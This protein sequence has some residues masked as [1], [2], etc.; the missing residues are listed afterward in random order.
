MAPPSKPSLART[1]VRWT[2]L[3]AFL[4]RG[5]WLVT[6]LYLV[7]DAELSALQLVALGTAQGLT[8][9][10]CEIPTGLVADLWSRKWS[11]VIAHGLMG[12][13]MFATGLTTDFGWLVLTQMVWGLSWTF[14]SGADVAWLTDELA[15]PQVTSG[16]L[17]RAARWA[18]VGSA[19]GLVCFGLLG[20]AS[21]LSLAMVIA[22]S[23]MLLLGGYVVIAFHETRSRGT[24]AERIS[25]ARRMSKTLRLGMDYAANNLSIRLVLLVTLLVNGADEA[26][27]RL[28]AKR[29]LELGL[30]QAPDPILWLTVLGL[31][32]LAVGAL[33]LLAIEARLNERAV[34]PRY[35]FIATL[36]A[37]AG[38]GLFAFAPGPLV[39]MLGVVMVHGL[40]LNIVRVLGSIWVN[41][42][43]VSN[44]RATLQSFV[45]Q[46]E[47]L[48]EISLGFALGL[49]AQWV[50]IGPAVMIAAVIV[51]FAGSLIGQHL[52]S[53]RHNH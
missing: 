46:A 25:W 19:L 26:F 32:T 45:A 5:W 6:S 24:R 38:M 28:F 44:L 15:D 29:L 49:C 4:H 53:D 43:A 34:L 30:P 31:I 8:V 18:Q 41:Q 47:N 21:S 23:A 9:L 16:L 42:Q 20:W 40:A 3:R 33:A 2:L 50:G 1:Y 14:S 17:A 10:V 27:S 52:K 37:A 51:L 12:S 35:Y 36:L 22:G 11:I 48:G 7:V 13:A 39:A